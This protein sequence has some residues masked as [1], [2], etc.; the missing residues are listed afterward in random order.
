[1][2]LEFTQTVCALKSAEHHNCAMIS[3]KMMSKKDEAVEFNH[4][5]AM[6]PNMAHRM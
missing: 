1:M 3:K 4:E 5:I 6:A 2:L